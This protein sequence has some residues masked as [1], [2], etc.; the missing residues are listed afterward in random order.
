MKRDMNLIRLQL[1]RV[2][3]AQPV[4]EFDQFTEDQRIYHM[5]LCIEAGF[6]IGVIRTDQDGFLN[7]TVATRLTWTGHE[8][9]DA[10]RNETVWNKAK[11]QI[12]KS[13][14]EVTIS[15]MQEL[16]KKS[17]REALGLPIG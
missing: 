16:L 9:L 2:E 14:V 10:A 5:A 7:G 17:L 3:G 8:F 12:K 15:I 13:G 6:V 1:M 11:D 4:P